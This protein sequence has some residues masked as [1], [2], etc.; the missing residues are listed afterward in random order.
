ME[1]KQFCD[2]KVR[3]QRSAG[4]NANSL[5]GSQFA[6]VSDNEESELIEYGHFSASTG[7]RR[8][9]CC[10]TGTLVV[11]KKFEKYLRYLSFLSSSLPL[12]C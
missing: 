6:S 1:S 9:C 4:Q 2:T 7:H 11:L 10:K 8:S 3:L 5:R 12:P